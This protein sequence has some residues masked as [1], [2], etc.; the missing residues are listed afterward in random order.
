MEIKLRTDSG[1]PPLNK[2]PWNITVEPNRNNFVIFYSTVQGLQLAVNKF[3]GDF[4]P[5]FFYIETMAVRDSQIGT[6]LVKAVTDALDALKQD[7]DLLTFLTGVQ[8]AIC[9]WP[10]FNG[11]LF[12]QT[13]ELRL[14]P[15]GPV[16]ICCS[17]QN[18]S[19]NN[20]AEQSL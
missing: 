14:F 4:L 6:W 16:S 11:N 9:S 3:C 13:P 18:N 19:E 17:H 5:N 7:V 10:V 15:S 2:S 8:K 12:C 20:P 1:M